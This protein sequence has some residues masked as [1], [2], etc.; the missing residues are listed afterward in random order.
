MWATASAIRAFT[1]AAGYIGAVVLANNVRVAM[2]K[3]EE[4]K[5]RLT[6]NVCTKHL[7][8][9]YSTYL[10]YTLLQVCEMTNA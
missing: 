1:T 2:E 3:S 6:S 7:A 9:E 5:K 10:S 8:G 4:E